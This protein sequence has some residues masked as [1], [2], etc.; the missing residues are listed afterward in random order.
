ML[1]PFRIILHRFNE[2]DLKV[3]ILSL[4]DFLSKG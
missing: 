2:I 3:F 1:F 4:H